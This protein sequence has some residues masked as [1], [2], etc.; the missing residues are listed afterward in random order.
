MVEMNHKEAHLS[1]FRCWRQI[2]REVL[3]RSG[4]RLGDTFVWVCSRIGFAIVMCCI[5]VL[6]AGVL[7]FGIIVGLLGIYGFAS[8]F[9][10]FTGDRDR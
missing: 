7:F 6:L 1:D 8:N 10:K 3:H 4:E 2:C 5:P 9:A